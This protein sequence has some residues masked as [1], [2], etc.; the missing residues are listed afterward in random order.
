MLIAKSP[1]EK[2]FGVT[3]RSYNLSLA[4]IS[5]DVLHSLDLAETI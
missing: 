2:S 5:E 4:G 3:C 1:F